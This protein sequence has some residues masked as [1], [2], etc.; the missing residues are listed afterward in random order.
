MIF[1]F[2]TMHT[3]LVNVLV[4]SHFYKVGLIDLMFYIYSLTIGLVK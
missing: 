3:L 1:V 4:S 2:L